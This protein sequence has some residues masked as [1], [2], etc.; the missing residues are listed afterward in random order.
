MINTLASMYTLRE[1]EYNCC[2]T[3]CMCNQIIEVL[4]IKMSEVAVDV[5]VVGST[6]MVHLC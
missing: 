2:N 6:H 1:T 4:M 3:M 5:I